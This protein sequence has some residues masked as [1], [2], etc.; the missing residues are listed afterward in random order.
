M[1]FNADEL[2]QNTEKI[3]GK[4]ETSCC[5]VNEP[6]SGETLLNVRIV[7]GSLSIS[8]ITRHQSIHIGERPYICEMCNKAFSL[9]NH[10]ITHKRTHD[11]ERPYIGEVCN[12]AFTHQCHLITH[13]H[14][15]SG[16]RPYNC[17]VCNKAFRLKS[18]LVR[19][20]LIHSGERPYTCEV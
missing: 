10:L 3:L 9:Q 2:H 20:K 17:G 15:H 5:N 14:V 4:C 1:D 16:E 13:K 8:K 12:E 7:F 19:H 6:V 11:G 18:H